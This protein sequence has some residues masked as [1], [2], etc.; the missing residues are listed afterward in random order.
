MFRLTRA[1]TDFRSEADELASKTLRFFLIAGTTNSA[2]EPEIKMQFWVLILVFSKAVQHL[3]RP[4]TLP[5]FNPFT[6]HYIFP[7]S[8]SKEVYGSTP[9]FGW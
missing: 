3:Q 4:A 9:R 6:D 5:I 2:R 1:V 8:Q 7:C